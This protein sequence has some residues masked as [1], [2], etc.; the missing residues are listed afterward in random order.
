MFFKVVIVVQGVVELG[1][2][3]WSSVRVGGMRESEEGWVGWSSLGGGFFVRVLGVLR[4][5]AWSGGE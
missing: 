1:V 2:L 5:L 4:V 3:G